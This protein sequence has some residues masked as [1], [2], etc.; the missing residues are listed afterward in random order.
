MIWEIIGY[1]FISWFS[2]GLGLWVGSIGLFGVLSRAG[3]GTV[4]GG[5]DQLESRARHR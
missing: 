4:S 3:A 1:G 2:I 5:Y